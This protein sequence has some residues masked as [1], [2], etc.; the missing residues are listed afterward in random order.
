MSLFYT[1]KTEKRWV[2]RSLFE[3]NTNE[4]VGFNSVLTAEALGEES[5][6]KLAQEIY[7]S[8]QDAP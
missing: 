6:D 7:K 8:R 3:K 2:L 1:P 5:G 4:G